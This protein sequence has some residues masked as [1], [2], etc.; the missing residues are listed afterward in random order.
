MEREDRAASLV[1]AKM[2]ARKSA[3]SPRAFTK[4]GPHYA[5]RYD[6][7]AVLDHIAK[8]MRAGTESDETANADPAGSDEWE[9][10]LLLPA[11]SPTDDAA[12]A[13]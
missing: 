7:A 9:E 3:Q 11:P 1:R 8:V 4:D 13:A 5:K 2:F 10:M 6:H 12:K